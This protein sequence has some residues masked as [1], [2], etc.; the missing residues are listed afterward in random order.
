MRSKWFRSRAAVVLTAAVVG[1]AGG[2]APGSAFAAGPSSPHG[3]DVGDN[4]QGLGAS[5]EVG[6]IGGCIETHA[7][8]VSVTNSPFNTFDCQSG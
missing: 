6:N 1:V 2:I 7:G 8:L 3:T 5:G 4:N